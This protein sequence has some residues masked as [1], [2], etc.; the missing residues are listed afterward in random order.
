VARR[1]LGF[2][3]RFAVAVIKPTMTIMTRR[4]WS[5]MEHVPQSGGMIFAAN[6]I[7]HADPMACA[8]FVYDSGRWPQFLAKAS[9]FKVPL[10][11]RFLHAVRQIPVHR[12]TADAAKAIEAAVAAVKDGDSVIIY[13]EGTNTRDPQL[14]PMRGKT[15]V[16]RLALATGAPVIPLVMWGPQRLYDPRTKKFRPVPRTPVTVIAGPP[17]DLSPWAGAPPTTQTLYEITDAIM[18]AVRD[19]LAE[20]RGETPPALWTPGRGADST[21]DRSGHE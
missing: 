12:G 6:H 3:R 13:P 16:A 18:R 7:S 1:R 20:I 21:V 8:H 14:W 17:V 15:G 19:I 5:G 9:L 11:G 2:W 10:F 4:T